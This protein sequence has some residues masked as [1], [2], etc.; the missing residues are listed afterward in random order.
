MIVDTSALMAILFREDGWT[1][2]AAAL[3]EADVVLLS[4]VT[5]VEAGMVA[6]GRGGSALAA[7]LDALLEESGAEVWPVSRRDAQAAR[8]AWRRF[9]R[10]NH[11]ARLNLGDCFAYALAM[12]TGHDLLFKGEDFALTDV[13]RAL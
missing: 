1:R 7:E 2:Y 5:L 3:G 9:G 12:Q 4:A 10:G 8:V 11:P 13:K 6:E